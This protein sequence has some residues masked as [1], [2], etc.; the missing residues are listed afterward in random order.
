MNRR[1]F[2]LWP[3][4]MFAQNPYKE[5]TEEADWFDRNKFGMAYPWSRG[6]A[7][8]TM[9]TGAVAATTM[10]PK[11][12]LGIFGGRM[13]VTADQQALSRAEA[14]AKAGK[15][16]DEIWTGTGWFQGPDQK[17]RF[18][19]PDNAATMNASRLFAKNEQPLSAH[20]KHED[21]FNAYPQSRWID[22]LRSEDLLARGVKGSFMG[23]EGEPLISYAAMRNGLGNKATRQAADA[24]EKSTLLHE[25]QHATQAREGFA[26]GGNT[27]ILE[28]NTPAW[29][30]YQERLKVLRNQPEG[31]A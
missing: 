21:L 7:L 16:P 25:L 17:W 29:Q 22:T 31:G 28:P 2:L 13:A 30:L 6:I 4:A 27:M 11:G 19:I 12:S 23:G 24:Q 5:G 14:M 20:M 15:T 8:N 26:R 18:E 3:G 10:V 1:A 9:G